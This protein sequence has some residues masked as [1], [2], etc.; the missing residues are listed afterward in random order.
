MGR[1]EAAAELSVLLASYDLPYRTRWIPH[2]S[3]PRR[4]QS[5]NRTAVGRVVAAYLV[6]VG[7]LD[8]VL[9]RDW[10]RR[11]KDWLHRC[12]AASWPEQTHPLDRDSLNLFCDAFGLTPVHRSQLQAQWETRPGTLVLTRPVALP[13]ADA[14]YPGPPLDGWPAPEGYHSTAVQEI[15][16]LGPDGRPWRHRTAMDLVVDEDG[17]DHVTYV[18]AGDDVLVEVE[19]GGQALGRIHQVGPGLWAQDLLFDRP[20]AAGDHFRVRYACHYGPGGTPPRRYRRGGSSHPETPM[21]IRVEFDPARLPA[22]V[23]HCVWPHVDAAPLTEA[24]VGLDAD[25]AVHLSIS[26]VRPGA[27]VGLRWCW[28]EDDPE[29]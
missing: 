23:R 13:G 11:H 16:T 24:L 21:D 19:Q 2:G 7:R 15:H 26:L 22:S 25:H 28:T 5:V 9:E 17:L 14:E 18:F 27:L 4:G 1:A 6:G 8:D 10:P 29:A 12:L 20:L 3:A